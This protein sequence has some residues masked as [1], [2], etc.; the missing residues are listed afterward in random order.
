MQYEYIFVKIQFYILRKQGTCS[1]ERSR[2]LKRRI[3]RRIDNTPGM[4]PP[5]NISH[6]EVGYDV[7]NSNQEL[8]SHVL[9]TLYESI[10]TLAV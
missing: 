5:T 9:T 8:M 3:Y 10:L 2:S 7:G 1:L 6:L 4:E